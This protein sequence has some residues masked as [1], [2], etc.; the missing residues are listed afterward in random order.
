MSDWGEHRINTLSTNT[1][2][3]LRAP[4]SS[5]TALLSAM[6]AEQK[7]VR[8]TFAGYHVNTQLSGRARARRWTVLAIHTNCSTPAAAFGRRAHSHREGLSLAAFLVDKVGQ[9]HSS[10]GD[11][12]LDAHRY[13]HGEWWSPCIYIEGII[14]IHLR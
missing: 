12:S 5:L 3:A 6:V 7:A 1:P 11:D 2:V 4:S 10:Y 8:N 9:S 14:T 13:M